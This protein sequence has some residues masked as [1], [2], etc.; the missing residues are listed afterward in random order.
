MTGPR[1]D[2]A[3]VRELVFEAASIFDAKQWD[4]MGEVFTADA[5]AYGQHGLAAI[6]AN[7]VAYLGGCGPTQHLIGNLRVSVDGDTATATSYVRAFH[8]AAGAD[9]FA[10]AEPHQFWDFLGEYTDSFARG[11]GGWRITARTC[12]PI[13]G[14]GTLRLGSS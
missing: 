10:R 3:A 13:A 4:R 5:V 6:T 11:P 8:L 2:H 14:S 7:T 9:P 1:D 12:R